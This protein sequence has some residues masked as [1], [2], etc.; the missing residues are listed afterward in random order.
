VAGIH[1]RPLLV[2]SILRSCGRRCGTRLGQLGLAIQS[3]HQQLR[4]VFMFRPICE[5]N[6]V[7]ALHDMGANCARPRRPAKST[8]GSYRGFT[9]GRPVFSST[10]NWANRRRSALAGI[11]EHGIVNSLGLSR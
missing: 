4:R 8:T 3:E 5:T 1:G 6:P 9:N 10:H 7:P 11:P 2:R